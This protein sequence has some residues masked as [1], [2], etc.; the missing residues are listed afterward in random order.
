MPLARSTRSRIDW[1]PEML[2]SSSSVNGS[3]SPLLAKSK[4]IASDNSDNASSSVASFS[5]SAILSSASAL[6]SAATT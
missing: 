2:A 5:I 6:V 4:F 1:V 3:S